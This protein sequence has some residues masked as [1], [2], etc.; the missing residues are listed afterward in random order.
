MGTLGDIFKVTDETLKKTSKHAKFGYDVVTSTRSSLA[1]LTKPAR[2][3]PLCVIDSDCIQLDYIHDVVQCLQSIFTGYYLQA[4]SLLG[5]VSGV[6]VLGDLDRVNPHR[7]YTIPDI[8]EDVLRKAKIVESAESFY[9]SEEN[10]K[11]SLPI[12]GDRLA[13]EANN[14]SNNNSNNNS[15]RSRPNRQGHPNYQKQ[16]E[17]VERLKKQIEEKEEQIKEMKKNERPDNVQLTLIKDKEELEAK[18]KEIKEQKDE[19]DRDRLDWSKDRWNSENQFKVKHSDKEG[20]AIK[21]E[22]DE[23]IEKMANLS[24][25]KIVQVT[26][27]REGK[28]VTVPVTIRLLVNELP[29][30]VLVKMFGKDPM[31]TSFVERYYKWKAGRIS[32]FS[33]LILC[34]DLVKNYKKELMQDENK[35]VSEIAR[36]ANDNLAMTLYSKKPSLATASNLYIMSTD[37]A[38]A[39]KRVSGLDITKYNQR[40]QIFGKTYAMILCVIDRDYDRITFYHDGI[41][42]P[43]TLSA[44]DLRGTNKNAE[45]TIMDVLSAYKQGQAPVL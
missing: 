34:R 1:K 28:S 9:L 10:Y 40:D 38:T 32:F 25:G 37:T 6:S 29:T 24:V 3:E 21:A 15:S 18:L 5:T 39:I 17:E 30:N 22:I 45:P 42:M 13:L 8:V 7:E 26:I 35:V 27:E 33:D 23:H 20:K 4:I 31:E 44:R 12:V 19:K 14:K 36:R 11:W 41:A 43:T 16:R 2:V